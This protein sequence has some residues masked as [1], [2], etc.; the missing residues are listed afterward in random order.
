MFRKADRRESQH[1]GTKPHL[2]LCSATPI[3]LLAMI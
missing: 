2:M 1:D 3:P